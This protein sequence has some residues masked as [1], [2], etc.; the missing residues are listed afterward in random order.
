MKQKTRKGSK[1]ED[2]WLG[3]YTIVD[4][5]KTSCRL[6]NVSGKLLKTQININQL[7]P[8]HCYPPAISGTQVIIL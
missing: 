5:S 2:H 8:Y 6:K 7:K 3:P 1:N 4:I